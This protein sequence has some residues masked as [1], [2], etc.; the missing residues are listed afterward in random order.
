MT[1]FRNS[2]TSSQIGVLSAVSLG[3]RHCAMY[4][5]L[6]FPKG[7]GFLRCHAQPFMYSYT[8]GLSMQNRNK[9]LRIPSLIHVPKSGITFPQ[10]RPIVRCKASH[11][12]LRTALSRHLFQNG[13]TR[14]V[15]ALVSIPAIATRPVLCPLVPHLQQVRTDDWPLCLLGHPPPRFLLSPLRFF[16]IPSG[17]DPA[18]EFFAHNSFLALKPH[19]RY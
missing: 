17:K 10:H 15:K 18:P 2:Q 14:F 16:R 4:N 7:R 6:R 3:F 11:V 5:V 8:L 19:S 1:C 9:E 12:V 13:T